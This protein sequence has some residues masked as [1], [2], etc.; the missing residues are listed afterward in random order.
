MGASF[1]FISFLACRSDSAFL[2][3]IASEAWQP[4]TLQGRPALFAIAS[5]FLLAMTKF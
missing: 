4:R 1:V 3:V 2:L 5:S